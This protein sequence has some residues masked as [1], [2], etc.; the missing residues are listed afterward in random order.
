MYICQE[1]G[2]QKVFTGNSDVNTEKRNALPMVIYTKSIRFIPK[3]FSGRMAL[4]VELYGYLAGLSN[5][6][7][8]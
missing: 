5:V 8:Q 4:R 1:N 3:S 2:E 7:L 6:V